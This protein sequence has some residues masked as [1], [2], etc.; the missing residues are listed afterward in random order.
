MS[1][2]LF[3]TPRFPWPLIGGDRVKSYHLLRHLAQHHRV[4][5]VTFHHGGPPTAEQRKAI[6]DLGVELHAHALDPVRAGLACVRSAWTSLPLEIAFY[7]RPDVMAKVDELVRTN[8]F[9]YAISFFMRTAEYIR[10]RRTMQRILIAEDCRLEYQT[11]SAGTTKSFLQRLVRWWEMVKL[12]GYEPKVVKDFDVTTFVTYEDIAAMRSQAPDGPYRLVTNG[13]DLDQYSYRDATEQRAGLLFAGKLN[14]HANDIMAHTIIEDILPILRRQGLD[15]PID[16]VGSRPRPGL[17]RLQGNGVTI[18][19]DVPDMVPFLHAASI[20]VHPHRAASGIQNK[21]LEAMATG[22][23]VV[24]TPSGIQ[25]IEAVHGVHAMIGTTIEEL[26]AHIRTLT[27][28]PE[29]RRSLG[30]AARELMERTHAWP[31]VFSQM[32]ELL[33]QRSSAGVRSTAGAVMHETP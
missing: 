1:S 14:V 7:T 13:V 26:A 20:F 15:L 27:E 17:T 25:G 11:R 9:D 21:V 5:L 28:S 22:C 18:H 6:E 2:I 23:P 33:G 10:H 16:I 30:R 24:T 3:C 12:R 32:D 4:V 19:A 29:L 31:F 8:D